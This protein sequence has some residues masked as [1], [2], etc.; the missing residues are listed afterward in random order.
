M[1][2][3]LSLAR[4]L[5]MQ[6]Q[7]RR[8][9]EGRLLRQVVDGVAAIAQLARLAVDKSSLRALEIDILEAAMDLGCRCRPCS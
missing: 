7:V 8:L 1:R 6:Q 9:L 2:G 4:Q 3:K 5:A